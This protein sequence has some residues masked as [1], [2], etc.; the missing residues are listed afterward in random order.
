MLRE[1]HGYPQLHL[2][3]A[4]NV[5]SC[6]HHHRGTTVCHAYECEVECYDLAEEATAKQELLV[7]LQVAD[8]QP[9]NVKMTCMAF[10]PVKNVKEIPLDPECA[11]GRTVHIGSNLSPK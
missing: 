2:L 10:K 5:R 7:V 4:Q 6:K 3:E 8:E 11:D 9:P 1:V